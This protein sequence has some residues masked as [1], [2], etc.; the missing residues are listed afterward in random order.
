MEPFLRRLS[1]LLVLLVL[2]GCGRARSAVPAGRPYS[3][4]LEQGVIIAPSGSRPI[5]KKGSVSVG[6][7]GSCNLGNMNCGSG[8]DALVGIVVVIAIVMVVAV[9]V[10]AVDAA[11][12][13]DPLTEIYYVTL[14]GEGVP[15]EVVTITDTNHIYLD[16]RQHDGLVRGVYTR[17]V[18]RPTVWEGTRGAPTQVV[19]VSV[20]KG[21]VTIA[22][23]A[24]RLPQV[25]PQAMP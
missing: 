10:L 5:T 18:I 13:S 3:V 20:A 14:S 19:T 4:T 25:E 24:E 16:E 2:A 21:R 9:V 23:R 22:P 1:F 8:K 6:G 11:T 15:L 17:A 7:S 12:S